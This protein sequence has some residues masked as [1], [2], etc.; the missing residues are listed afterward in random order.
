MSLIML[1]QRARTN[2]TVH[3]YESME[4]PTYFDKGVYDR[5]K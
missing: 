3:L 1:Q 2:A 4:S 5:N